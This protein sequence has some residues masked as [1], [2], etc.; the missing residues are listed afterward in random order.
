MINKIKQNKMVVVN[1]VILLLFISIVMLA[2][3]KPRVIQHH[4]KEAPDFVFEDV[5][6]TQLYN[7][8]PVWEMHSEKAQI[9]KKSDQA[10][11]ENVNLD[12][13]KNL[14]SVIQLQSLT[15]SLNINETDMYFKDAS[16]NFVLEDS[17]KVIK[18]KASKLWWFADL[19]KF[20]GKEEVNIDSDGINLS[21]TRFSAEIP[22]RKM[23]VSGKGKALIKE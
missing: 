9:D 13:F 12:L 16:A 8:E 6:I 2:L 5:V 4:K 18:L 11:L 3:K 14:E 10:L 22:I 19:Q 21:G 23:I 20:I 1:I 15:A 17:S 7:G